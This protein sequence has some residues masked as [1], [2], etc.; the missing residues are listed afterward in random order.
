MG[1]SIFAL[2]N[3]LAARHLA[4]HSFF[5][6]IMQMQINLA[7]EKKCSILNLYQDFLIG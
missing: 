7:S 2:N 4:F 6:T 3:P 5:G 1:S